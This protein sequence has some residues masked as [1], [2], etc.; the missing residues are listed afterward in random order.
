M[1]KEGY[2]VHYTAAHQRHRLDHRDDSRSSIPMTGLGVA[3]SASI[4]DLFIGGAVP[5][6]VTGSLLMGIFTCILVQARPTEATRVS[7]V[8]G[9]K[10]TLLPFARP[11]HVHRHRRGNR[12]GNPSPLRER[13]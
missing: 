13:P 2:D 12:A 11:L 5:G 6:V 9:L 8:E 10:L 3:A 1:K 4:R 7:S